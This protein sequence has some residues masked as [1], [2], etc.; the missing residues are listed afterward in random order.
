MNPFTTYL[1]Q[2]S[3]NHG[4]SEFVGYWDRLERLVISVYRGKVDITS[5]T[6]EFDEVWPWLRRRYDDWVNVLHP[7]WQATQAAGKPTQTDPFQLLL[8]IAD[9]AHVPGNWRAMQHL[10]A[11]REAI[12]RYLMENS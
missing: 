11:A 2:W 3:N 7:Y 6:A 5:A 4:F 10:P 8:N 12:N 9:L 1:K